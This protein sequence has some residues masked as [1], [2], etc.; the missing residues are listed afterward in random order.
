[1]TRPGAEAGRSAHARQQHPGA[2]TCDTTGQ[3]V[4]HRCETTLQ[5]VGFA[6]W[7]SQQPHVPYIC[8]VAAACNRWTHRPTGGCHDLSDAV[9]PALC[10]I[11]NSSS[12]CE[13][14]HK[15]SHLPGS[16]SASWCLPR[17]L[18]SLVSAAKLIRPASAAAAHGRS[19]TSRCCSIEPL[20]AQHSTAKQSTAQGTALWA[21]SAARNPRCLDAE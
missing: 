3:Q 5:L 7:Q 17:P 13:Q 21:A 6:L 10:L 11:P 2:C 9:G 1:M 20:C 4:S 12:I 8:R 18:L 19:N 14:A 16:Y 15:Q